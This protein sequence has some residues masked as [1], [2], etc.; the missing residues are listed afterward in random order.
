MTGEEWKDIDGAVADAL[1]LPTT[2]RECFLNARFADRAEL[3]S[4]VKSL[5]AYEG[6]E[7]PEPVAITCQADFIGRYIGPY[8]IT[9]RAGEGGMGVVWCAERDDGQFQRKVAIKFLSGLFASALTLDRFLTERGILA[10]L[11]HP[12]I[13]RLLDAGIASDFEPYLI[14]EWVEGERIDDY[15][16]KS[17]L[18]VQE[19]LR[20]FRQVCAAV[21]YAHRQLVVHR[22]LKPSN[23]FVAGG[24]VK[25]L[26]FGVAKLLDPA[27]NGSDATAPMS[28]ALTPAYSSPE[29]LRGEPVSTSTDIY[30][31]GIDLYELLTGKKPFDW[32][33]KTLG[34]I[35][36]NAGRNPPLRP[37][38][39]KAGLP[40][41]LDAM[42]LK[43]L[44][45]EPENRYG[46]VSAF[47]AD[48]DNFLQGRPIQARPASSIYI[49]RKFVR[50]NWLAVTAAAIAL[51][52][53]S[54]SAIIAARQR[55]KADQ[56]FDQ[57][58]QLSSAVIFEYEREI[59]RLP[60]TLEV[61]RKMVRRS[62]QYLDS[63]AED[64]Q[65]EPPLLSEIARGYE[66]LARVQ[67]LPSQANLGDFRGALQSA[68]KARRTLERLRTLRPDDFAAVCDLGDVLL[69]TGNI[70][71]R[72]PNE[73][74]KHSFLDGIQLWEWIAAKYPD[75]ERALTGSAAALFYKPDYEGA[76]KI[77]DDL[78]RRFPKN[79]DHRR[80]I[81]MMARY[82][83]AGDAPL[84]RKKA[85][86][87]RAVEIDRTRVR[88]SPLDR[89][90]R[91]DLS[92]DLSELSDWHEDSG[93][94]PGAIRTFDE[95]LQIRE[96]LVRLDPRD[97]QA[98]DRLFFALWREGKLHSAGKQASA[99]RGYYRKAVE[100]GEEI[101]LSTARPSAKLLERLK[102]MKEGFREMH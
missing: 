96:E 72:V 52:L 80:N 68:I 59:R 8:R 69:L 99:A 62:L 94:V 28:R 83:A 91:L 27:P 34:E 16:R 4:E 24:N 78:A 64:A 7:G 22:D 20:L 56:R 12:N 54:G 88:E 58:R 18:S 38:A 65:N 25:L 86:L 81:A 57:L 101:R 31:L 33:G 21:E 46:S 60:G 5:L 3:L 82:I 29:Q 36:S 41:E 77:Y 17:A 53:I 73:D 49:A 79:P 42:I 35:V 23:I 14:M 40:N 85:L 70:Q 95:V 63:L 48:I 98:K 84:E 55:N 32:V 45:P 9:A 2:E 26:D 89:V 44:A 74:S 76:L 15:V 100:L 11:D 67:G 97:E 1:D 93:D 30:S 71:S 39:V 102:A 61:R 43:T 92:F 6:S 10:R 47:A 87:Q 66:Q 19:I 75:D 13:A 50:R 37:S 90:A 51:C